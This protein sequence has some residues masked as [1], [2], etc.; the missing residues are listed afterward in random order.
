MSDLTYRCPLCH[1]AVKVAPALVG[2]QIDC[3]NCHRV[4]KIDAPSAELI[5]GTGADGDS[6]DRVASPLDSEELIRQVHPVMFRAHPFRFSLLFICFVV[7]VFLA[8]G[9]QL[10]E[11]PWETTVGWVVGGVLAM[12]GGVGLIVWWISTRSLTLEVTSKRTRL[13]KGLIAKS[14]SEVQHDDVRNIQV[15]QS[16]IG[17]MV[18]VGALAISSSGQDD[19]EITANGLPGPNQIAELI[20]D[21][22]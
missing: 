8:A 9:G 21:R 18:N 10:F 12:I 20:R 1:E 13:T 2:E 15:H 19:L 3:P 4:I 11:L 7:G 16:I 6:A 5:E 17:R 14:T 22:Q